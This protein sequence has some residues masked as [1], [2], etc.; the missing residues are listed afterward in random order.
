MK[1]QK[2]NKTN[3]LLTTILNERKRMSITSRTYNIFIITL[4]FD[5]CSTLVYVVYDAFGC[6]VEYMRSSRVR[7]V[8]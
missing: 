6:T 8:T 7:Y 4:P 5:L 3:Q 1:K 2:K